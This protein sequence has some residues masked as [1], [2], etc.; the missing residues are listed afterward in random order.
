VVLLFTVHGRVTVRGDR[1]RITLHPNEAALVSDPPSLTLQH[2]DSA[3]LYLLRFVRGRLAVG[4]PRQRL[5]VP[6]HVTVLR[7]ARLTHLLRRLID[8]ARTASPSAPVLHHLVVL[9]LCELARSSAVGTA[10]AGTE[11]GRESIASRVDAFVAAHYHQPIGTPDI[12]R[13]LHYNPDYLERAYHLERR[14][15]I[16]DAVHAR[17]IKEARAQLIL[18]RTMGVA[19]IA[20]LCGYADAGYF[21]RVFKRATNMTP[22][23]YRQRGLPPAVAAPPLA[24]G[25]SP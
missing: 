23:T 11:A 19:E 5:E 3:D 22:H 14:M 9:A 25:V 24:A 18:Q 1:T 20:A 12:A 21:R 7:P 8:E 10:A 17:R 2:E 13:E 16:R 15:S 4:V 6:D